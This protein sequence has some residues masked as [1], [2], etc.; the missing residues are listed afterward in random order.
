MSNETAAE[1][2]D[3]VRLIPVVQAGPELEQ[4]RELFLEYAKSLHFSLCFQSF[5]QELSALPGSYAP[6]SGRLILCEVRGEPAGCAALRQLGP[7]IAELKRM[8]VRPGFRGLSL[9][10]RLVDYIIDEARQFGYEAI[11]LDTIRSTMSNAIRLYEAVGFC[12]V[13]PYCENPI[14]DA[15]YMELRL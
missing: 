9:G 3:R 14:P 7:G 11:R 8:Y 10:R 2:R 13:A 1:L 12:E 4:I 5:D 15:V 6:P